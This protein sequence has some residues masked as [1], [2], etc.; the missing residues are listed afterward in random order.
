MF[1]RNRT[2][3]L[4]AFANDLIEDEEFLL[5]Y[6]LN[7]SN[8]LDFPYWQYDDFDLDILTDDECQAEFIVF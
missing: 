5:L 1:R 6:D 4:E 2:A 3:L 7:R 8:A